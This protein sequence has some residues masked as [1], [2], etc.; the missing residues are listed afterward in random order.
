MNKRLIA[1]VLSI[2]VLAGCGPTATSD[3][4][5]S[6]APD[7]AATPVKVEE[8]DAL[9]LSDPELEQ[10]GITYE[11]QLADTGLP[12]W[13]PVD[14]ES[15]PCQ[16]SKWVAVLQPWAAFRRVQ[17]MGS[18]NFAVAQSVALYANPAAAQAAF[19]KFA[20]VAAACQAKSGP[21][22]YSRTSRG[23]VAWSQ[24]TQNEVGE[25]AGN[26]AAW[27]VRLV[28]NV[29]IYVTSARRRDG[30]ET[31]AKLADRIAAKA[32]LT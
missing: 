21:E 7:A 25:Y 15:N 32:T 24:P 28:E 22:I 14:D 2:A 12:G 20:E 26:L 18:S 30:V 9:L 10:L 29:M 19:Q 23:E 8:I 11:R 5:S 4:P 13:N 3:T 17:S 31:V 6:A 16:Q 27:N 1:A